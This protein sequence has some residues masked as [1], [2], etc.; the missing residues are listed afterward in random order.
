VLTPLLFTGCSQY[1]W[2]SLHGSLLWFKIVTLFNPLTY[3]SELARASTEPSVPHINIAVALT[4]LIA[5]C[6]GFLYAG[7]RGFRR[8]SVS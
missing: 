6:V 3:A 7:I 4:A 8:R 5:A 1:P 2:T